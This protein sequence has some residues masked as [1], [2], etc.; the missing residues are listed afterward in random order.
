MENNATNNQAHHTT[1]EL[2]NSKLYVRPD[3]S[4]HMQEYQGAPCY[5]IEDQFNSKFFRVGLAEYNF[6]SLLDGSTTVSKAVAQTASTMGKLALS[7][8]DAISICK[9]LIDSNLASTDASRSS[10]RLVETQAESSRKK[11]IQ[12]LNPISPKFPLFNPDRAL[13]RL[14]S[15]IGWIFSGPM[16][17]LWALVV[18]VAV[19]QIYSNWQLFSS[20]ASNVLS[21]DNW[22]WLAVTW[23]ML[24]LFHE[25]AHGLA[26]KR[27]GG[28]IRQAGI[29]LIVMIPLPFVDVTSSWRL[30]SKW[31]RIFI[32]AA[33]MYAE[34]FIAAVAAIIWSQCEPGILRTQCYNIILA[35]SIT[36]L[37]FNAN[38]L[39]RFDG[40]YML[41]D[42]LELPN[43]GTHGQQFLNWVGKKHYLGLDVKKPS[44]PEGNNAIIAGYGL[45]AAIWKVL[46]C[47]V[48]ALAAESLFFGA[49]IVLAAIAVGMW[50][51]WPICK[52]L[53]FVFIGKE[54]EEKPKAVRFLALT[55]TLAT[56][57]WC[58]FAYMPWHAR[59]NAPAIVDFSKT[60]E[61]RTP[62]GGFFRKV[63]VDL[64]QVVEKGDLIATLENPE[65][66]A[67]IESLRIDLRTAELRARIY[68]QPPHRIAA[69]QVEAK[70]CESLRKRLNERL[71]QQR[72]LEIVAPMAGQLVADRFD[73]LMDTY[74]A[75]G[76]LICSVG[77]NENKQLKAL[78]SQHDFELFKDMTGQL[79]DVHVWG[80]GPGRFPATLDQVNPRARLTLP[81]PAFNSAFGGPLPVKYRQPQSSAESN[82]SE[83]SQS[84]ELLNPRF[85][86]LVTLNDK[87]ERELRPGQMG[88]VSFRTKRGTVGEVLSERVA[89]WFQSVREADQAY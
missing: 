2:A 53:K 71:E 56:A 58:V 6:I 65:L 81:S 88:T 27:F 85:L 39:M 48:L 5:L 62:V 37:F 76:H 24:K 45:A 84:F 64:D 50:V 67:D 66:R 55:S 28:D 30:P 69:Y 32:A 47:A 13:A 12:K 22:V 44:W 11:T 42:W 20:N 83:N 59:V 82:Q 34:I 80:Q 51:L 79:V 40:Y 4:F 10:N 43:L 9:W 23:V 21:S 17:L 70:N 38:P 25:A 26:C 36:T 7:E 74:L 54:T 72:N 35:G 68:N 15:T 73:V 78:V 49:G 18:S 52:L 41:S 31:Q 87:V 46:I 16:F 61:V 60:I 1:V 86:A 8:S 75:P 57:L 77:S 63:H 33:G 89:R 19:Y 3:L 14:N 29:V